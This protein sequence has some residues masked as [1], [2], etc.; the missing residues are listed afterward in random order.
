MSRLSWTLYLI[1][2]ALV[3]GSWLGIVDSTIAWLG[4]AVATAIAL[5]SWCRRP[6]R[7]APCDSRG[8]SNLRPASTFTPEEVEAARREVQGDD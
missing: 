5:A 8:E 1:G 3:F 7:Q 2:S 4:W 6:V